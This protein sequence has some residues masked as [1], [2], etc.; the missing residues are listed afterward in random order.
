MGGK[1]LV[2]CGWAIWVERKSYRL[3]SV[4]ENSQ[5]CQLTPSASAFTRL[6][7]IWLAG[8]PESFR[9]LFRCRSVF[10]LDHEV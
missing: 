8:A 3:Q 10:S 1:M 4:K 7:A 5:A 6:S 9:L 2:L